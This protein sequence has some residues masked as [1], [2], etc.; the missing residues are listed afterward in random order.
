MAGGEPDQAEG[1]GPLDNF[2]MCAGTFTFAQEGEEFLVY[3]AEKDQRIEERE[4]R[5]I[6]ALLRME[7]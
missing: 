1:T 6:A 3:H 5:L 4:S 2:Q 7:E